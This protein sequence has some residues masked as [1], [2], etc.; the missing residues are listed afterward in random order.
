MVIVGI[1]KGFLTNVLVAG[2][3]LRNKTA[4]SQILFISDVFLNVFWFRNVAQTI[5]QVI[6]TVQSRLLFILNAFWF[7]SG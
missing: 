4:A 1:N 7:W 3:A 5:P 2:T 6:L